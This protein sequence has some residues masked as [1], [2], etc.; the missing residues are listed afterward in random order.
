MV[1]T[2]RRRDGTQARPLAATQPIRRASP[3]TRLS[4]EGACKRRSH[5]R[6]PPIHAGTLL[7][8]RSTRAHCFNDCAGHRAGHSESLDHERAIPRG[9]TECGWA[10]RVG[11]FGRGCLLTAAHNMGMS[12][13]RRNSPVLSRPES[14]TLW[15]LGR[16]TVIGCR[17]RTGRWSSEREGASGVL[18]RFP[19]G[20]E[21]GRHFPAVT[22]GPRRTGNVGC[23]APSPHPA[24]RGTG[25]S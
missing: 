17:L 15:Q 7:L 14:L 5:F 21:P 23:K 6:D 13:L 18:A 4:D 16:P 10:R 8:R 12:C 3:S 22:P 24:Y 25:K 20:A 1:S 2:S 9:W 11:T 19:A